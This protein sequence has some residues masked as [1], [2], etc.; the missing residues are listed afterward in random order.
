MQYAQVPVKAQNR[1]RKGSLKDGQSYLNLAYFIFIL[2]NA[3]LFCY[4]LMLDFLN[5]SWQACVPV[6][7]A[8]NITK[9][10]SC[11]IMFAYVYFSF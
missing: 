6:G 1:E 8:R 7:F 10:L 2:L 11:V 4:I 9:Q 5:A 3:H